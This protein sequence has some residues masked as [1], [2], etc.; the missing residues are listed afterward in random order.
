MLVETIPDISSPDEQHGFKP[1]LI[2]L[3][4]INVPFSEF[5][6]IPESA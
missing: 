1:S 6:G 3:H 4:S 2:D 5:S